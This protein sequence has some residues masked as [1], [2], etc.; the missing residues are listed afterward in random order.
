M[1][2]YCTDGLSIVWPWN[3]CCYEHD[4]GYIARTESKSAIDNKFYNCV[5]ASDGGW[6]AFLS[7]PVIILGG[8]YFWIRRKWR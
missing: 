7:I 4:Q 2:D 1:R 6:Y 5:A 3:H 8:G